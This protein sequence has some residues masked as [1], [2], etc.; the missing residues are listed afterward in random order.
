MFLG[1]LSFVASDAPWGHRL[2][3]C[4]SRGENDGRH[5]ETR[6]KQAHCE[7]EVGGT[8]LCAG[9]TCSAACIVICVFVNLRN[10]IISRGSAPNGVSRAR[11]F[12]TEWM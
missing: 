8:C 4:C 11:R 5:P 7:L 6:P 12:A 10:D 2:G 1:L 9:A 3:T